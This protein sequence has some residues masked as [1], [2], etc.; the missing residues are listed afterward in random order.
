M[1]DNAE[2]S[3][4]IDR[5][6]SASFALGGHVVVVERTSG[7]GV[8]R[9]VAEGGAQPLEIEVTPAGAVLRLKGALTVAVNGPLTLAGEEVAIQAARGLSLTSGGP[10]HLRAAGDLAAEADAHRIAARL[11]SV[12]V[13]ASDDVVLR[14]ERIK[15]N[16]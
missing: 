2:P 5:A 7:G 3:P 9:L 8:L 14:G 6:H 1:A 11:G 12:R 13:D 10:M 16:C 15:L 4:N